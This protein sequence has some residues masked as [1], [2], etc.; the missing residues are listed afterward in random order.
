M[1]ILVGGLAVQADCEQAALGHPLARSL[2]VRAIRPTS[3]IASATVDAMSQ[4]VSM[5]GTTHEMPD[6]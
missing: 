1:V 5:F 2:T 4:R 6:R 3:K